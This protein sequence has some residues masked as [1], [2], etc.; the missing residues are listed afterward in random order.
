[1]IILTCE[2]FLHILS[3]SAELS[4]YQTTLRQ[5]IL[6][7]T[8]PF[9]HIQGMLLLSDLQIQQI[10]EYL[11]DYSVSHRAKIE[12]CGEHMMIS[13]LKRQLLDRIL[14]TSILT[15]SKLWDL[16]FHYRRYRIHW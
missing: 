8:P 1:M 6:K 16:V 4:T 9:I 7:K 15:I 13:S 5:C 3:D 2:S 11:S 14:L 10:L 12:Y